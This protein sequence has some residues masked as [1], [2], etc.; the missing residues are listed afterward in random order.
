MVLRT[1]KV[2]ENAPP[3]RS[4]PRRR[5]GP[6]LQSGSG[7]F[8]EQGGRGEGFRLP[9]PKSL[10]NAALV[11]L[12]VLLPLGL[13][14]TAFAENPGERGF[15]LLQNFEPPL[16]EADSQNLGVVVD[17]R[18]QVLVAN[19][20]G[21]LTFDG[22]RWGHIP[23]G[24]TR[25]AF[26]IALG[27]GGKVA[28]GGVDDLGLLEVDEVGSLGFR[29]LLGQVPEVYRPLGQILTID[30]AG[31]GFLFM[32]ER[33]LFHWDGARLEVLREFPAGRP[34][35]RTFAVGT[36]P[37]VWNRD[38]G[39]LLFSERRLVPWPGGDLFRG[40]RV[41]ALLPAPG[42]ILV[43]VRGEGLFL[44]KDGVATPW[45]PQASA[46]AIKNRVFV[47]LDLSD[48]RF[49]FGSLVGGAL[50]VAPDGS[51]DQ[52]ID[53]RFG[54]S[55]DFVTGL[56]LD[57]E[58]SLWLA[59]DSGLV[60]AEISS[61]LTLIDRRSG[62]PGS[63]LSFVRHRGDLYAGTSAGLFVAG[64]RR[65]GADP[66]GPT[67]HFEPFSQLDVPIWGLEP[68]GE[69]LLIGA[70]F[71]IFELHPGG[72]LVKVPGT[73]EE[74]GYT[75]LKSEVHPG[76][77]WVGTGDGLG[78]LEQQGDG[79]AFKGLV[80]GLAL[81]A[82]RSLVEKRQV[83]WCGTELE[84][85]V[86]IEI[87]DAFSAA[88]PR[89][90]RLKGEPLPGLS[91]ARSGGEILGTRV[92][93]AVYRIDE[94]AL[95]ARRIP[96]LAG[97]EGR[98]RVDSLAV[99]PRGNLWLGASPPTIVLRRGESFESQP[100][101]LVGTTSRTVTTTYAEADGVTW[102][103]TDRGLYRYAGDLSELRG[104]LPPS[105][106]ALITS[107]DGLLI[108][109]GALG[110]EPSPLDLPA[111]FRRLHFLLS[112]RSFRSGLRFETRLDPIDAEW[113]RPS[114]SPEVE[115]TRLP[116]GD[117]TLHARTR[118]PNGELGPEAT[119]QFRVEPKWTETPLAYALYL[120]L[121]GIV[122]SGWAGLRSRALHR[123]AAELEAQVNEKTATLRA[124]VVKLRR[125]QTE[126]ESAN[127]RLEELSSLDALTGIAN[128]RPLQAELERQWSWGHRNK[129]P[130]AFLL[131]D[132]DHFKLLNDTHGHSEGDVCLREVA[133]YL[134]SELRRPGDLVARYGGEEF[135][136]LL[137]QTSLENAV[138]MAEKLRK[139][140]EALGLPKDLPGP[141]V[142][143]SV[144]VAS[145]IPGAGEDPQDLVDEADHALYDAK[146]QGRNRV[147]TAKP[148]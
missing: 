42:G 67:L 12:L 13:P 130:L 115:I 75:F 142:T 32:A 95:E 63:V 99:D 17:P 68:L 2:D 55:D 119:F 43:S 27:A 15:P 19:G 37:M 41:D 29:S 120:L 140:I 48:G 100:I 47:A 3:P 125:T 94:D 11:L 82:V 90:K 126:L 14:T 1:T 83:L 88:T 80:A 131:L 116:D 61:P 110:A 65:G 53:S 6:S 77:I 51:I 139:G 114:P 34:V 129:E 113:S 108:F 49:A 141:R 62:L 78:V 25:S 137:P 103:G 112:P 58:G 118:G 39:L 31:D 30:A 147:C 74:V 44:L 91:L 36:R 124:T 70:G 81:G 76:R 121:A 84:G 60:R 134:K 52:L 102:L 66:G 79:V 28:V 138:G 127:Y 59:L 144:G 92:G 56:A 23:I 133:Q 123:R 97:L 93:M 54:L 21:V 35:A 24:R 8:S 136:I 106:F 96:E 57:G 128:R 10:G 146:D 107:G 72:R 38:D 132:L 104:T 86:G 73:D 4:S 5:P 40:R 135:A 117:Y 122:A 143:T 9:R 20:S 89:L 50:L 64:D 18:G 26:A 111:R 98:Q 71:G 105:G 101:S 46:W 45:S 85:A 16:P 22:A 69:V 145:R 33:V 87:G 148:A 7:Y 109:G